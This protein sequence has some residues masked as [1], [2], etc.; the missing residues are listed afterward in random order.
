MIFDNH[1]IDTKQWDDWGVAWRAGLSWNQKKG[2]V[3]KKL[4]LFYRIVSFFI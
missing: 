3:Y 1:Q 2:V 4:N